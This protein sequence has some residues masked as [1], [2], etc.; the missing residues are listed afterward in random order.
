[1]YTIHESSRYNFTAQ[2]NFEFTGVL[3]RVLEAVGFYVESMETDQV[4][5]S[6]EGNC[7]VI[8]MDAG[9]VKYAASVHAN[10]RVEFHNLD[11]GDGV[12]IYVHSDCD[13][14]AAS[15]VLKAIATSE[16]N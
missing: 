15:E 14:T 12:A 7:D 6:E 1:M 2:V 3:V 16:E 9:G 10:N 11:T 13:T 8:Y 4:S 5:P